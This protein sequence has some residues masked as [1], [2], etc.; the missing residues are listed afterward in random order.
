MR[1]VSPLLKHVVY[2]GLSRTG[3]LR[4]S[5]QAGPVAVTYHGLLPEGYTPQG[6]MLDGHLVTADAFRSQILLLR[7]RYNLVDPEQ[8]RLWCQGQTELPP[9]SVLLTCDDGL[10]NNLTDML[11]IIHELPAPF[12]FFV[13]GASASAAPGMLWHEQLELWRPRMKGRISLQMPWRQEP[14]VAQGVKQARSL[15]LELRR[16]LSAFDLHRRMEILEDMR[17]QIGISADWQAEYSQNESLRRRF[18]MLNRE[19]LQVLANA[20]IV[21]GAH[22]LSHPMLSQMTD[23]L[24]LR[25]I[26]ESRSKIEEAIGTKVWALAYPFGNDEAVRPREAM[27]ARRAG[28]ECAFLNVEAGSGDKFMLPRIHVSA[29]MTLAELEAHV[30][31]FYRAVRGKA[32]ALAARAEA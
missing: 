25:E 20:G 27:L 4:R 21:I 3:Y 10:L 14:Y 9:R 19:Q 26:S 22:T 16:R 24:A 1:F 6:T 18:F 31:G 32:L 23:D 12:L 29:D 17:I 2:P 7:S 30:S 13:T 15:W 5:A 8:F 28:F 11:P